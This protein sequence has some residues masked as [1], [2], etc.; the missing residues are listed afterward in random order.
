MSDF[1][2]LIALQLAGVISAAGLVVSNKL[3]FH[4]ITVS[5]AAA[6]LVFL[7]NVVTMVVIRTSHACT[8]KAVKPLDRRWLIAICCIG[9]FSVL[10]SNVVLQVATVAFHQLSR[11]ASIPVGAAFDFVLHGKR[12]SP[13]QLI[14]ILALCVGMERA[15]SGEV[16]DV[17]LVACAAAAAS[18]IA[19][20]AVAVLIRRVCNQ[21]GITTA[22]FLYHS[23]PWG[24]AVAAMQ[25][26]LCISMD[27]VHG[28]GTF[29]WRIGLE[30][31]SFPVSSFAPLAGNLMLAVLVQYLSTWTAGNTNAMIYA[32]LGQA[33][34]AVTVALS[35]TVF[36]LTLS[37]RTV[38]GFATCLGVACALS[39]GEVNTGA[40]QPQPKGTRPQIFGHAMRICLGLLL[41]SPIAYD[42][43]MEVSAPSV[44]AVNGIKSSVNRNTTRPRRAMNSSKHSAEK[45]ARQA[46]EGH[47]RSS[48]ASRSAVYLHDTHLRYAPNNSAHHAHR[49][50]RKVGEGH[51]RSVNASRSTMI[52]SG[53]RQR[54]P[55]G[56]AARSHMPSRGGRLLSSS[57]GLWDSETPVGPKELVGLQLPYG[58]MVTTVTPNFRPPLHER[59]DGHRFL[60]QMCAQTH[61]M[62]R[63]HALHTH[64]HVSQ[65]HT[66]A[67]TGTLTHGISRLWRSTRYSRTT[68]LASTTSRCFA[69]FPRC[70]RP[71]VLSGSTLT[72]RRQSPPSPPRS[73]SCPYRTVSTSD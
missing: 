9:S 5:C 64:A 35:A 29:S 1:R 45:V 59:S 20:L 44:D 34:T 47:G 49:M 3:V 46:D 42:M 66:H 65:P 30:A 63:A 37:R 62:T 6:G 27:S 61:R 28:S 31:L 12:R 71:S 38:C 32:V 2:T 4:K 43:S 69:R 36:N 14:G 19:T 68:A 48:K 52:Q 24:V 33:K 56:A 11:M 16:G 53:S 58:G 18:V 51:E 54:L 13:L 55:V 70:A 50:A 73:C 72:T 57:D 26:L 8:G 41:I 67:C 60:V 22:Q 21:E 17:T 23:T 39:I 15:A 25:M 7:H 10:M 40:R